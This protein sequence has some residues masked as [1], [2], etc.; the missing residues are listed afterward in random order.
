MMCWVAAVFSFPQST[1]FALRDITVIGSRTLSDAEVVRRSGLR[2]GRPLPT[3]DTERAAAALQSI[4]VI[5]RATV[6]FVWPS[7]AVVAVT[8]RS[9]LLALGWSAGV[10][11]MDEEGVPF[12]RQDSPG[13]LVPLSIE[14]ALPWAA[15]G[16]PVPSRPAREVAASFASLEASSREA[17]ASLE[18][19]R[20]DNLVVR[21]T[22]G[23]TVHVGDPNEMGRQ[24]RLAAEIL[25][26]LADR[27][28]PVRELDLRFG[29][30]V[31]VR[32]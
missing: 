26:E 9:P 5:R 19:D 23:V 4:P 17:I 20:D 12:R 8:E 6:H 28:I 22:S 10:L 15:L 18:V 21:L 32:P 24:M 2:I 30:K 31:V 13:G 25:R 29:D 11:V 1:A 14:S 27:G 16:E 7:R 3:N